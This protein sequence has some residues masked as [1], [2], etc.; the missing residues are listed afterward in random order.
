MCLGEARGLKFQLA[1]TFW[2]LTGVKCVRTREYVFLEQVD[3]DR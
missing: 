2:G 1:L 3:G